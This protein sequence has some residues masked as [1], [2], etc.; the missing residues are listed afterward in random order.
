MKI[1]RVILAEAGTQRRKLV[2]VASL[3]GIANALI[4]YLVGALVQAPDSLDLG[5]LF[6]FCLAIGLYA[7]GARYTYNRMG[8]LIEAL[9]YRLRLRIIG[10][11]QRAD[12]QGIERL[13]TAEIYTRITENM[14]TI[15]TAG[16]MIAHL[17]QSLVIVVA[18]TLYLVWH[19]TTAFAAIALLFA[20]GLGLYGSGIAAVHDHLRVLSQTR[21]VF[22]DSLTDLL[23]GFKE[24][25]YSRK[26]T[27]QLGADITAEALDLRNRS[28]QVNQLL[29]NG[30]VFVNCILY[31]VLAALVMIMPHHL[32]LNAEAIAKVVPAVLLTWG[33]L[34]G[35]VRG[36][37]EYLRSNQ[38]LNEIEALEAKLDAAVNP[39][40]VQECSEP[41]WQG[42]L[43]SIEAKELQYRYP[44]SSDGEGFCIGPLSLTIPSG[45]IVFVVGGNGSGK[46][47]LL[48]A[49]TGLYLPTAGT[50]RVNGVLV[51]AENVAAYREMISAVY[52]DFHLFKKLYGF[53]EVADEQVQRML[54]EMKLDGKTGFRDHGFTNRELS[55]GQRK[56]LA[57]IAALAEDRPLLVLDEWAADQDPEFRRYFYTEL[58]PAL[59]QRGKTVIAACHDDRYFHCA[60]QIVAMEE[61]QIR[62]LRNDSPTA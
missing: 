38:A 34:L 36:Y 19:S 39:G 53:F 30:W 42:P 37:G 27:Q 50:L 22:L 21:V 26:R 25:K 35:I 2:A 40:S 51:R 9:L 16:G 1:L 24:G 55:T 17:I 57:M 20:S 61:G 7:F 59:K 48:K 33:P 11:L 14:A 49:L 56:R 31:V 28:N 45:L 18:G 52:S 54:V 15:S 44:D 12:L 8:Q 13:G 62:P 58:L 3:S 41:A 5:Q 47:T 6:L 32:H 43:V 23:K 10:K 29:D 60:D 46:S 4:M